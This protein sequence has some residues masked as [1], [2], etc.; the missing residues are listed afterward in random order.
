M[1]VGER[2][3]ELCLWF[4]KHLLH[5]PLQVCDHN[6]LFIVHCHCNRGFT[7][8]LEHNNPAVEQ[9]H[10]KERDVRAWPLVAMGEVGG[11]RRGADYTRGCCLQAAG[12][13]RSSSTLS[14]PG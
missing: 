13:F 11:E 10:K 6:L 8:V 9:H 4:G 3:R 2:E 7:F 5:I 14:G 12:R 1:A